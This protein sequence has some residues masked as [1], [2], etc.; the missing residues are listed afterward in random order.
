MVDGKFHPRRQMPANLGEI[1][2]AG[3][4]IAGRLQHPGVTHG[5]V[6]TFKPQLPARDVFGHDRDYRGGDLW[7][8]DAGK[9][10]TR[11]PKSEGM[12]K[13]RNPKWANRRLFWVLGLGFLSDF[14][15]RASGFANPLPEVS[16]A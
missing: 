7:L 16:R 12:P 6:Q 4:I 2:R 1:P 10:E 11:N 14:W 8:Q 15:F 9:S 13:T 5:F 3:P